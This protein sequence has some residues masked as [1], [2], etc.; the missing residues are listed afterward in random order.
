MKLI[1]T[2]FIA[3]IALQGWCQNTLSLEEAINQAIEQN[4]SIKIQRMETQVAQNQVFKGNAGKLPSLDAIGNATYNNNYADVK[5][6]TF[7]RDPEFINVDEFGVENWL[8]TI[9]VQANYV[10]YDGGRSDYRLQLLQGLSDV[11]QAKQQVLI[12]ETTLAVTQLY[13]EILKL[14]N[15]AAFLA[16]NI[17]N[18]K[19]R[20]QKMEDRK[21]FG[22]ANQLSILQLQ[23]ALNQDEAALDNVR[24]VR[25]NL[26]KDLNF[27]IGVSLEQDFEV[28]ELRSEM[29]LS[30]IESIYAAISSNNPALKLSKLGIAL[31]GTELQLNQLERQPSVAAFAGV[32]YN[33][34]RND[35][36][37]L[38]EIQTAGIMLGVNARYNLFDGGVRKN[39]IQS[40]QMGVEIANGKR[41]LLEEDL[42][43]RALKEYNSIELL[44]AQL[45]REKQ[46]LQTSE[47]AYQK[48]EDLFATGK[49]NNLAL[50]DAQLARLNVLLRIE[51]LEVDTFM[52]FM[53][54]QQLMGSL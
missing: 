29:N 45:A 23:T 2:F 33:Y 18:S 50:R 21:Q 51:Q 37:Q 30:D 3:F 27:L 43:K 34:Q 15:Q 39:K 26:V 32:G 11:E 35:V 36:Q 22:Q 4:P 53:Q 44:Q 17:E 42:R 8:A 13:L 31:A 47:A 46:N 10:I 28:Q 7:Q 48:T 5:L 49:T 1:Y 54:L 38:A 25:S 20:I 14:Q 24:L 40:A 12:S 19:L 9:G 16:E 41:Q 52:A 6:R